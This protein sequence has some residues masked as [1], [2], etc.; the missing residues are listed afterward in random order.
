MWHFHKLKSPFS[1]SKTS[2]WV[3]LKAFTT[4]R[5]GR[6]RPMK[7]VFHRMPPTQAEV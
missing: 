6:K 7:S 2:E 5:L 3:A 1:G 4:H